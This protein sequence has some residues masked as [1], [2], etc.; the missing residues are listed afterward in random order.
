M[1]HRATHPS[2]VGR[3]LVFG[4][5]VAAPTLWAAHAAHAQSTPSFF[6]ERY[7]ACKEQRATRAAPEPPAR[8][9]W[10]PVP[11]RRST[12]TTLPIA[13]ITIIDVARAEPIPMRTSGS[14]PAVAPTV[15]AESNQDWRCVGF[16]RGKAGILNVLRAPPLSRFV[17][18]PDADRFRLLNARAASAAG[19]A[20]ALPELRRLLSRPVPPSSTPSEDPADGPDLVPPELYDALNVKLNAARALGDLGDASSAAPFAA[21][22]ATQ[23]DQIYSG[24]WLAALPALM[25]LDARVT[26]RYAADV[27]LRVAAEREARHP[28]SASDDT[29]LR[30]VLPLLV[31]PDATSLARL[32]QLASSD[33]RCDVMGTR[34]RLG[35]VRLRDE[36]RPDLAGNLVTQRAVA[37]YNELMPFA[38]PGASPD[39]SKTLLFRHRMDELLNLLDHGRALPASDTTWQRA[40]GEIKEAL[41]ARSQDPDVAGDAS[42]RRS[43]SVKRAKHLVAL[44]VLGDA[45]ARKDAEQLVRSGDDQG[46]APWVAAALILRFDWPGAAD[47]AAQR[48]TWAIRQ[49]TQRYDTELDPLRGFV[50]LTDHVPVVDALAARRDPRFALGLL[51]RERS[52]REATALHLARLRLPAACDVVADAA[53]DAEPE[54]VQDAF[55]ALTLLGD[56]CREQAHRLATDRLAPAHV[57]GMALELSAMLR[58][59]RVAAMLGDRGKRDDIRPARQRARIIWRARE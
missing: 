25:R 55:W 47:L 45:G 52:V 8:A 4:L 49:P 1:R 5:V 43:S 51:D 46:I 40:R 27:I 3:A 18:Y 9:R 12:P 7:V 37:C 35:D 28:R 23:E 11:L 54:A 19:F 10:V 44:A 22:L 50:S 24:L 39:E 20:E 13:P 57:R 58:D 29:L 32:K 26:E 36:L 56:T 15:V 16:T 21:H 38:F 41:I 31:T 42:D 17:G 2:A 14:R 34:I 53:P 30:A 6:P 33:R 48:L 59:P